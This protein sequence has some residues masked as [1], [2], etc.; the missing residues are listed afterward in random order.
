[1]AEARLGRK[2]ALL[3]WDS[4]I[5]LQTVDNVVTLPFD[6]KQPRAVTYNG[7]PL[8]Y[9]VPSQFAEEVN[10]NLLSATPS[11]YTILGSSS[12]KVG[13]A[14]ADDTEIVLDY[15]ARLVH[16]S[17]NLP[18]NWLLTN[19]PDLLVF[20]TMEDINSFIN[21]EKQ[22]AKWAGK[23]SGGIEELDVENAFSQTGGTP[24]Q[25]RSC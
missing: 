2:L 5:I 15:I 8:R 6:Y 25:I 14:V 21:N 22:E 7:T 20:G 23:F 18:T 17:D 12:L 11:V 13:P 3:D 19:H 10:P 9:L 4:Q 16:L 1:M 24:L